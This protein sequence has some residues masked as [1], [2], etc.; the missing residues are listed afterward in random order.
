MSNIT[1]LKGVA[2]VRPPDVYVFEKIEN[3]AREIFRRHSFSE[4]RIP[5][6][7][8]T[9]LFT[10]SIGEATDIVEKEMYTF[11]DKGGRSISLRPEGTASVVRS[12]VENRMHDLPPPQKFYYMGPMFRYERPQ[13][14]RLRQFYQIGAEVFGGA[15]AS[16]DA[17][18]LVMIAALL[19]EIRLDDTELFINSIGCK[20]KQCRPGFRDALVE[21]FSQRVE[22]L[23]EDCK[24]R[25]ERN[26]LRILD[27]KMEVCAALRKDSPKISTHLC[28]GCRTHHGQLKGLLDALGVKYREDP[29]IV[30][31]LDYYTRTT[32][33]VRTERL[34]AQ[35][36][37]VAGGRY[38]DL[39]K[40][41]GGP[42]TPAV[43]FAL[44]VERVCELIKANFS[45]IAPD[46][47]FL[48]E[49][50]VIPLGVAAAGKALALAQGL[51]APGRAVATGDALVSLK[52]QLKR[53][54]KAGARYAVIVGDDEVARGVAVWRRLSD[55]AQGEVK[56]D[57]AGALLSLAAPQEQA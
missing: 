3:A 26:P 28:A 7:E 57:D 39:V 29:D 56:I 4:L 48:P 38:D 34:G 24:K 17:E 51:R 2:D 36:A 8:H 15:S 5:I 20:D 44:G 37:V 35:N 40:E 22:L 31:G 53:A 10:R 21:Y 30:R 11:T 25:L 27:C 23:C 6:I 42:P 43:G 54:D 12:Y 45:G 47:E 13:K 55:G 9:G 19:R 14:G 46:S 16:V 32:F 1:T 18:L 52:S 33:E 49:F 41:F 50:Y